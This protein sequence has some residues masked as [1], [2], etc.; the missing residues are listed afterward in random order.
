MR[1]KS[2]TRCMPSSRSV[3]QQSIFSSKTR[4]KLPSRCQFKRFKCL[5]SVRSLQDGGHPS[6]ARYLAAQRF[7]RQDRSEGRV[8]CDPDLARSQKIP[9]LCLE[10]NSPRIH[11]FGLA[12][13]PRVF[14]KIMKPV[15]SLLR[16]TGI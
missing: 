10:A 14:T 8:F 15:V 12:V 4:R 6:S 16:R 13:A 3:C 1:K 2:F 11:S 7:A 5:S 9:A